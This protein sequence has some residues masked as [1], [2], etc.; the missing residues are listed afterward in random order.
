MMG[1][2]MRE[3][4]FFRTGRVRVLALALWVG[5]TPAQAH[6]VV[7]S[8]FAS[9]ALI[10]G[11]IG[12]SSGAMAVDAVVEVFDDAGNRLGETR[13]DGEGIFTFRPQKPV[14][15]VFRADLG[16]GH[17][18]MVR[19]ESADLP[20]LDSGSGTPENFRLSG[21]GPERPLAMTDRVGPTMTD[22][23]GP[24]MTDRVGPTTTDRVGPTTTDP[25]G[26]TMTAP[27]GAAG[28]TEGGAAVAAGLTAEQLAALIRREVRPLRQELA[29]YKEKNDLQTILGGIGYIAGL[30]GCGFYFA[31]RQRLRNA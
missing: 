9:G 29:A 21:S 26:S 19:L 17:V 28:P 15:H 27:V 24:T 2:K 16:A 6:K 31:A 18:A 11:E 13:T 8:V 12:F 25:V 20:A 22:R 30:F 7:A 1:G 14:A 5:A 10:E 3:R 23:V 4:S